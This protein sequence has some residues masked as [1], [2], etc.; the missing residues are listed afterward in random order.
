VAIDD[1]EYYGVDY[2]DDPDMVLVKG[3][4]FSDDFGK[5]DKIFSIYIFVLYF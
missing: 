5:K 1:Y 2:H 3:E 4:R